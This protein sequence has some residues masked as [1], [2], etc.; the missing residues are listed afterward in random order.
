MISRFS[1]AHRMG[2]T[3]LFVIFVLSPEASPK[4]LRISMVVTTSDVTG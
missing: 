4:I 3:L 2:K 1:A